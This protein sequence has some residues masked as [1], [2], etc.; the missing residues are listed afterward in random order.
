V[1]KALSHPLACGE[2]EHGF[3]ASTVMHAAMA[4]Y[5]PTGGKVPFV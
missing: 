3:A 5:L 1:K 2:L 4:F